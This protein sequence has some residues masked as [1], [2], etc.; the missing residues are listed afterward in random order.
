M[1]LGS[2]ESEVMAALWDAGDP[3]TVRDVQDILNRGRTP[4]LAYTTVLTVLQRLAAK[5]ALARSAHGRG[6]AYAPA[7]AD[8]AGL[9][10]ADV[11]RTYG[12]AAIARFVEAA[13]ADPDLRERLRKLASEA[14]P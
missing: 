12:D 2:L 6:H 7:V 9:A 8:E 4:Q 5:G 14:P 10:V 13:D 11:L 1:P 3:L